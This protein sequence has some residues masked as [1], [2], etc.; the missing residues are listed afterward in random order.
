MI[1]PSHDMD[2]T[3]FSLLST[4]GERNV[5]IFFFYHPPFP[6]SHLVSNNDN[7]LKVEF[8]ILYQREIKF[9]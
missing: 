7:K 8:P 6:P 5:E 2:D 9:Q 4:E 3:I 1:K